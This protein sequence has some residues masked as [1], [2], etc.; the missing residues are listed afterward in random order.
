MKHTSPFF[1]FFILLFIFIADFGLNVEE[2]VDISFVPMLN[3]RHWG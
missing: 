3:T 1:F 2:S